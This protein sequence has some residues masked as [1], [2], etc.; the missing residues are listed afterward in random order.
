MKNEACAFKCFIGPDMFDTVCLCLLSWLQENYNN[1]ID[2]KDNDKVLH[3]IRIL[4][5]YNYRQLNLSVQNTNS[6]PMK[7]YAINARAKCCDKICVV[8]QKVN[9]AATGY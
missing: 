5:E 3:T 6:L 7:W 2:D 9:M 4:A 8:N 1:W